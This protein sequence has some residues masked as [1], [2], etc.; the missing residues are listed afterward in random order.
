MPRGLNQMNCVEFRAFWENS[1][2]SNQTELTS[3]LLTL[4]CEGCGK[5]CQPCRSCEECA[6]FEANAKVAYCDNRCE[7]CFWCGCPQC[8]ENWEYDGYMY[9][10]HHNW[11]ER[12]VSAKEAIW[13][14]MRELDLPIDQLISIFGKQF[15]E[16]RLLDPCGF[17]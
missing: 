11:M 6:V 16:G 2:F 9:T 12:F 17:F 5:H 10:P 8:S 3:Y 14:R 13:E 7:D 1:P 4:V 15:V